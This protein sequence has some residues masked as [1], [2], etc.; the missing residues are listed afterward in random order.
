M[1][2]TSFL[3]WE[4]LE[5]VQFS[6]SSGPLLKGRGWAVGVVQMS[7]PIQYWC[8]RGSDGLTLKRSAD[9]PM[10]LT[11]SHVLHCTLP[12]IQ[13]IFWLHGTFLLYFFKFLNFC[14][15][16]VISWDPNSVHFISRFS[17]EA[18]GHHDELHL[19]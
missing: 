18:C 19:I 12:L 6:P 16:R 17:L 7:A 10:W 3:S 5:W 11:L 9:N 8:D 15:G 1:G 2:P 14:R 4:L 13:A